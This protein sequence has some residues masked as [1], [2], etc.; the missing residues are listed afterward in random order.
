M[1]LFIVVRD[2]VERPVFLAAD[3]VAAVRT[4][5]GPI[6]NTDILVLGGVVITVLD[7]VAE[8]KDKLQRYGAATFAEK[9][10]P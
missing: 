2:T 3:A 7:T 4:A 5:N 6:G 8:V 10:E 9:V 1:R